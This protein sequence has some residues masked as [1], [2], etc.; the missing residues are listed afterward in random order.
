M[1]RFRPQSPAARPS[2]E[3][4]RR[5]SSNPRTGHAGFGPVGRADGRAARPQPVPLL[6]PGNAVFVP[7]PPECVLDCAGALE[8]FLHND[9]VRVPLLVKAGLA[10]VQFETIHPF[11]D[12][13]GRLGRLTA[14]FQM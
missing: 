8:K 12:G 6:L 7:P 4:R 5:P 14:A 13:N 2:P 9:P 10:R 1:P 11:L 3:L